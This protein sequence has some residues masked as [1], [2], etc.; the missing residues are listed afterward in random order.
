MAHHGKFVKT[1]LPGFIAS[2]RGLLQEKSKLPKVLISD[3]FHPN[4]YKIM[5]K[6][7]YDFR[8][9]ASLGHIIKAKPYGLNDTQ[10]MIQSQGGG[11][12]TPRIGLGYILDVPI[13]ISGLF[14]DKKSLA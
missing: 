13:T 4:V 1:S 12:F 5:E 8:K 6:S 7:S 3:G 9:L 11:V 10:K 14:K 2:F